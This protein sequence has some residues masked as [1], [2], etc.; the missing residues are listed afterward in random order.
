MCL[1]GVGVVL[2][3]AEDPWA[4]VVAAFVLAVG[5]VVVYY[6]STLM[7]SVTMRYERYGIVAGLV[8]LVVILVLSPCVIGLVLGALGFGK[9]LAPWG[10][11]VALFVLVLF[12]P[13]LGILRLARYHRRRMAELL[14]KQVERM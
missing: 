4:G 5:A 8:V 7:A 11:T 2:A 1:G 9:G 3:A 13:V 14:H 10:A 12:L 6:V